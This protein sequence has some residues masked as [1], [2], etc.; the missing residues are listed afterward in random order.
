M[1]GSTQRVKGTR[2][3]FLMMV[4]MMAIGPDQVKACVPTFMLGSEGIAE[5]SASADTVWLSQASARVD[6]LLRL[7]DPAAEDLA[8]F[9]VSMAI[10]FTGT[11]WQAHAERDLGAALRAAGEH[12]KA[13]RHF[14]SAMQRYDALGMTRHAAECMERMAVLN[15]ILGRFD[16]AEELLIEA[17]TPRL[18]AENDVLRATCAYDLGYLA[19]ER[20]ELDAAMAHFSKS[21]AIAIRSGVH[22]TQALAYHGQAIVHCKKKEFEKGIGCYERMIALSD[23]IGAEQL[24]AQG[25]AGRAGI[26]EELGRKDEALGLYEAALVLTTAVGDAP[27]SAFLHANIARLYVDRKDMKQAE[28]HALEGLTMAKTCGAVRDVPA[29]YK[30]LY[31]VN[32][33][34]GRTS[35]ALDYMRKYAAAQSSLSEDLGLVSEVSFTTQLVLSEQ[36]FADSIARTHSHYNDLLETERSATRTYRM[37]TWLLAGLSALLVLFVTN[38]RN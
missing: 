3:L 25:I 15:I 21:E 13:L 10:P 36:M 26:V 33:A 2:P 1:I 35:K 9:A 17:M 8:R 32:E 18:S 19:A 29:L 28:A 4:L 5:S 31:Q 6:S 12:E 38:R 7:H 16:R 34:A 30:A 11:K 20:G 23:S 22:H 24:K 14:A 27:W 37:W